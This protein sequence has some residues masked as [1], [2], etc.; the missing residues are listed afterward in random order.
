VAD[1]YHLAR[2]LYV[3]FIEIEYKVFMQRPLEKPAA[4]FI[5]V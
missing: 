4:F 1:E 3:I 2:D 5:G